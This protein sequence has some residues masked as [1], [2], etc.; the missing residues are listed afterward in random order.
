M[1][2]SLMLSNLNPYGTQKVIVLPGGNVLETFKV[3]GMDGARA[4]HTEPNTGVV[5]FDADEDYFYVVLT[6]QNGNKTTLERYSFERK[7]VPKPEDVF[8]SKEELSQIKGDIA[9]VQQLVQQLLDTTRATEST[10]QYSNGN[11]KPRN[12]AVS[13]GNKNTRTDG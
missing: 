10:K 12:E 11:G 13:S 9:N 3:K 4:F 2:S 7:P 5:L 1:N 8:V 6:D